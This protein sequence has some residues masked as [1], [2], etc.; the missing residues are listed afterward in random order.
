VQTVTQA[1]TAQSASSEPTLRERLSSALPNRRRAAL[2]DHV[3]MLTQKVL[4][5]QQS[6]PFDVNEPLRQMGLD[7]LMA[8]ELRNLL[9]KAVGRPMPSTIT[10]DHPSV[11]ALVDYLAPELL[12]DETPSPSPGI[13]ASDSLHTPADSAI[14]DDLS[15]AE[16]A[17][18]LA[19]RLDRIAFEE[20]K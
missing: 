3:Q 7:S 6:G 14:S 20:P 10:F 5:V 18:R 16:L 19:E 17:S 13:A 1:A 9:S 8:V 11:S 4:G 12:G 2:Q 15:S